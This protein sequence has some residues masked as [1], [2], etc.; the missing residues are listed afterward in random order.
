MLTIMLFWYLWLE[1]RLRNPDKIITNI[2][3]EEMLASAD[4][5]GY[6]FPE[7]TTE[8]LQDAL[9]ALTRFEEQDQI[10]EEDEE[11]VVEEEWIEW[12]ELADYVD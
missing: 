9:E 4:D 10:A 2:H 1:T 11:E 7:T 3:Y 8:Q 5:E 12:E 6:N